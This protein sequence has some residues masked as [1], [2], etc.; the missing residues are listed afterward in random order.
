MSC[1]VMRAAAAVAIATA[2]ISVAVARAEAPAHHLEGRRVRAGAVYVG[3]VTSVRRLG[4][5]DGLT[6]DTQGRMEATVQVAKL[7]R[8]PAGAPA[9]VEVAVRFDSRAPEAEGDGYYTLAPG[10]ALLVFTDQVAEPAYPREVLHGTP[11]AL[12]AEVK[13]LRDA[14][15]A[16]DAEVMRFNGVTV[17]A[18]AGQVR[19]YDQAL[20]TIA[21]LPSVRAGR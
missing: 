7:L 4:S 10:E 20:A 19:L 9:A 6:A 8:A 1:A 15:I 5:L 11:E 18:R 3:T 17:W 13:S 14:L 2:V 12:A 21:R 16:M